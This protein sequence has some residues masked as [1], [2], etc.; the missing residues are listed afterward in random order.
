MTS[1]YRNA[2]PQMNDELFLADGGIETTLIFHD[3]ADLPYFA[4]FDLLSY[5]KGI[6]ILHKYFRS[7]AE[8]A[9][10]Y[11]TGL[12]LESATWR[13]SHDWGT[14]L[15]YSPAEL[16][17]TNRKSISL[18][19]EIRQ[20]FAGRLNNVVISGCIGPRG[21]GYVPSNTMY[22]MEAEQYHREQVMT[23]AN[24]SADLIS[25]ITMNYT[26]EAIGITRAARKAEM[27]VAISFTVET[28]GNLP[29]GQP[30]AEAI[31]EVDAAT[32]GYPMYY[33]INCAHPTHFEHVLAGNPVFNRV[34]GI[35]ANASAKSHAE[36]N[37]STTLDIGNPQELGMQYARLK[38]RLRNLNVVGG[39]CGTD[40]RHIEEIA[41][42]C[43]PLF[44]TAEAKQSQLI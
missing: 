30:L 37:E 18:L 42:A 40:H 7:Y 21:D 39:C 4:A 10:R 23:F 44:E 16:V 41:A 31:A 17:D 22:E 24:T 28:D 20:E 27:P 5:S 43:L 13:A 26:A 3:G 9:A 35:R 36:L 29:T 34:R 19:E 8:V 32:L 33:M 2:L 25:A 38:Q 1:K 15:G 11:S 14:K 6:D 12:V